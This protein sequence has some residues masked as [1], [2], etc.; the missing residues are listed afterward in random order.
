VVPAAYALSGLVLATCLANVLVGLGFP[1]RYELLGGGREPWVTAVEV[2][3]QG[4]R[5]VAALAVSGIGS[6]VIPLGDAILGLIRVSGYKVKVR[7]IYT[8][9]EGQEGRR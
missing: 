8:G 1:N 9:R 5:T 2:A 7:E 3:G 4:G 6:F